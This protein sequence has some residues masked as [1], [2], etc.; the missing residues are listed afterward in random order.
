MMNTFVGLI[1]RLDPT[2]ERISE[3]EDIS[4]EFSKIKNQREQI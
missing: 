1:S 4:T 3:P 2:E